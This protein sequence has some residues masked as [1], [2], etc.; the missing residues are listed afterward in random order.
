MIS[1]IM[2]FMRYTNFCKISNE[3]KGQLLY[4]PGG[5]LL[6]FTIAPWSSSWSRWAARRST[7]ARGKSTWV[8]TIT[9]LAQNTMQKYK[10]NTIKNKAQT[11]FQVTFQQKG[12]CAIAR[13]TRCKLWQI[14]KRCKHKRTVC[15]QQTTQKVPMCV[16]NSGHFHTTNQQSTCMQDSWESV[17]S[18]T[19]PLCLLAMWECR[20]RRLAVGRIESV[21]RLYPKCT[22]S[23]RWKSVCTGYIQN[24]PYTQS[25]KVKSVTRLFPKCTT[26]VGRVWNS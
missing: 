7:I 15:T 17:S 25:E 23:T 20:A 18:T 12:N 10:Q 19:P 4:G 6:S 9:F 3:K 16:D 2:V 11:Q 14:W 13:N 24:V 8:R 21:P 26:R 1:A 22:L 5:K